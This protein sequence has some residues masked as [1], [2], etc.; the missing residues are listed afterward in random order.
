M[1]GSEHIDASRAGVGTNKSTVLKLDDGAPRERRLAAWMWLD[2]EWRSLLSEDG[3][4]ESEEV[5]LRGNGVPV[6][7][8]GTLRQNGG[9]LD[10]VH[11][12]QNNRNPLHHNPKFALG[13]IERSSE[14]RLDSVEDDVRTASKKAVFTEGWCFEND[15]GGGKSRFARTDRSKRI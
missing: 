15:K 12:G 7:V 5:E 1:A 13:E 10:S 3:N 2:E 14:Q 4:Q 9:F 11:L 8:E 6:V